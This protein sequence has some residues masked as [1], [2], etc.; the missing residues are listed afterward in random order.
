MSLNEM[1]ETDITTMQPWEASH[2]VE[3]PEPMFTTDAL[4]EVEIPDLESDATGT[5]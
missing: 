2:E 5:K 1:N 3:T 4:E